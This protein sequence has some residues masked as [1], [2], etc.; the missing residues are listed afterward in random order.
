MNILSEIKQRASAPTP[1]FFQMLKKAGLLIAAVGTAVLTAPGMV[2]ELL[3]EYAGYAITAGTVLV[4][5]SQLT[6]DEGL[7]EK[8]MASV[9]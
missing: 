3:L 4:S 6:V 1:P 2:P 7:E 9:K 8:L 5:I